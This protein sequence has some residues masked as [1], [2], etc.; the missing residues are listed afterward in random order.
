MAD[1][2][3]FLDYEAVFPERMR[4]SLRFRSAFVTAYE[5]IVSAGPT[6]AMTAAS[7]AQPTG[8]RP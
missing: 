4:S 1:P 2:V 6:A 5:Q 7:A 3:A 8:G